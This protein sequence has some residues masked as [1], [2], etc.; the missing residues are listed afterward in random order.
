M[1]YRSLH[2]LFAFLSPAMHCTHA[3]GSLQE[4]LEKQLPKLK[5]AAAAG[6]GSGKIA[7]DDDDEE[8]DEDEDDAEGAAGEDDFAAFQALQ[9]QAQV[10]HRVF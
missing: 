2:R 7:E 4:K 5:N 9:A 6:A 8:D 1:D 10:R 3:S